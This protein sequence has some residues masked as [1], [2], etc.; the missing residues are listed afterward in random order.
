MEALG[1][2]TAATLC[3]SFERLLRTI[4]GG[5]V[6]ATGVDATPP[7]SVP[8]K[9]QASVPGKPQAEVWLLHVLVGDG[10]GTNEAAAK[11][12]WACIQ[13]R[14]LG[15]RVRYLLMVIICG[16]HQTGLAAKSAVAG[17]AAAV[18]A[19]EKLHEDI[20]GVT[21]RLYKFLINDYFDQF[22]ASINEWIF[23]D[24]E[25]LQPHEVDTAGHA[26]PL[27]WTKS[28]RQQ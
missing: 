15:P 21:V 13:E 10:I 12:L 26:S 16:T 24:L 14:G 17:R 18:A 2:K 23:R 6:P 3:A 27:S 4:V 7:A 28:A 20:A 25:I 1:D 8:G 9:P 22:V 11:L 5:L 19:R